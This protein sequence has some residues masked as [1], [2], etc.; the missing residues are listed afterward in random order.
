M[1]TAWV[2]QCCTCYAL[3][4]LPIFHMS[5][6]V[7]LT[8]GRHPVSVTQSRMIWVNWSHEPVGTDKITTIKQRTKTCVNCI[9]YISTCRCFCTSSM[10]LYSQQIKVFCRTVTNDTLNQIPTDPNQA[11]VSF[12]FITCFRRWKLG[13]LLSNKYHYDQ[14]PFSVSCSE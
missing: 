14:G 4:P 13:L 1:Q 12:Y 6:A 3:I 7:S 5:G 8:L 10:L 2:S 11:T 9:T